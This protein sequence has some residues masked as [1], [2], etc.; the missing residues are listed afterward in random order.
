MAGYVFLLSDL[1][2]LDDLILDGV[3]ST[4][5]SNPNGYWNTAMESTI[6]DYMT[7]NEGDNVYFFSKRKIYG[8]GEII[9]IKDQSILQNFPDSI[10]PKHFNYSAIKNDLLIDFGIKSASNRLLCC[11]KP[12]PYFF[13]EGIDMDDVLGSNPSKFRMLRLIYQVSFIKID[14]EENQSMKDIILK[15]SLE[16]L[17]NPTTTNTF[18]TKYIKKHKEISSKVNANYR[19][20]LE[21]VLP[22]FCNKI[23]GE[24]THEMLVECAILNQLTRKVKNTTNIFGHWN[25][26]SHQI[27]ASP[28]K[29]IAYMD[30]MDIFGYSYIPG[31]SPT[32]EKYLVI[33]VKRQMAF[34]IDLN[35]LMKYVDWIKNEYSN[36]DYSPINAFLVANDF[37][38]NIVDEAEKIIII[39]Y[40]YGNRPTRPASWANLKLIKYSFDIKTK[41]LQFSLFKDF[42]VLI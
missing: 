11:F 13:K 6:A 37:E 28:F 33:E 16:A 20:S 18:T 32:I 34:Q 40:T 14:D 7:M 35:Q 21:Q 38:E 39:N 17:S 5:M 24:L 27:G 25:Y 19:V 12:S 29:P 22:S 10:I 36:Q 9:K 8:I 41:G 30:R 3:Y 15:R 1:S 23:T 26:L 4:N 42:N 2:F 31:F